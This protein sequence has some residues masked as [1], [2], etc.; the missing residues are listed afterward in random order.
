MYCPWWEYIDEDGSMSCHWYMMKMDHCGFIGIWCI[1]GKMYRRLIIV[2]SWLIRCTNGWTPKWSPYG[3]S[4][5]GKTLYKLSYPRR[6]AGEP[7]LLCE[8]MKWRSMQL[9]VKLS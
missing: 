9:F 3:E 2:L 1:V 6:T 7:M 5:H 8:I 4:P